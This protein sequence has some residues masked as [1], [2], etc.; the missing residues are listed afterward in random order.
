MFSEDN[1]EYFDR[2]G[3]D[4]ND[5]IRLYRPIDESIRNT[6]TLPSE[7]ILGQVQ[8][9]VEKA[10]TTGF[11]TVTEAWQSV[12]SKDIAHQ[13]A[14]SQQVLLRQVEMLMR[15]TTSDTINSRLIELSDKVNHACAS[16]LAE[17]GQLKDSTGK[18]L[19]HHLRYENTKTNGET[20]NLAQNDLFD[21][22]DAYF[23]TAEIIRTHEQPGSHAG[24]FE[25]IQQ[26]REPVIIDVKRCIKRVNTDHVNKFY[27]DVRESHK[28]GALVSVT[29]GI[30]RHAHFSFEVLENRY[31]IV[32]VCNC[33]N[34]MRVLETALNIIHWIDG[35][36]KRFTSDD[37][38]RLQPDTVKDICHQLQQHL[39]RVKNLQD[40]I[41]QADKLCKDLLSLDKIQ[42]HLLHA[43]PPPSATVAPPTTTDPVHCCEC[44]RDYSTRSNYNQHL[45]RNPACAKRKAE[46]EAGA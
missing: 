25:I 30:T 2:V 31:V 44:N 35:C 17:T 32:F 12:H 46:N 29:S 24:D 21:A 8:K 4:G 18:L 27:R 16:I 39:D 45:R 26:G 5:W 11:G 3:V 43:A 15:S 14:S 28:H 7:D 13:V 34:D 20:G 37:V 22:M 36:L 19:A 41:H 40:H 42:S 10:F 9:T 33:Q 6:Q 38:L 23:H 1:A